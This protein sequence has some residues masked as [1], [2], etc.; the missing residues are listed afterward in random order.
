VESSVGRQFFTGFSAG[1]FPKN[2]TLWPFGR[3]PETGFFWMQQLAIRFLAG[4]RRPGNLS[5]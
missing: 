3:G 2:G 1:F 4:T 5:A